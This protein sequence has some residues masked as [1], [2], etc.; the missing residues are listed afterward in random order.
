MTDT[1]TRKPARLADVAEAAGVS[2]ATASNVFN[3]PGIVRKELRD[4]VLETA[5]QIGYA[6][7]DPRARVL[8]TGK[9]GAIGVATVEPLSYFFEDSFARELMTSIARA[10]DDSGTGLSLVSSANHEQLAWNL[11]NAVVD[12][13]LLYCLEEAR[14]LIDEA[15]DRHLPYV[16]LYVDRRETGIPAVGIDEAA[17]ARLATQHLLD[18]GHRRFAILAMEFT[19]GSSGPVTLETVDTAFYSATSGRAIG[20]LD[21]LEEAGI[22]RTSVPI[23]ETLTDADTVAEA[24]ERIFAASEP[25]TAFVAQS[26]AIALYA[27][28]WLTERGIS[29]P[30][31]VSLIGFD[32]IPEAA[33]STPPLTT[34]R[35]PL[36]DIARHAVDAILDPQDGVLRKVLPVELVVRNSTAPPRR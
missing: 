15:R 34:I 12:G 4:R 16:A 30:G 14:D 29:V 17:A 24:L 25:P 9:V 32:D 36:K 35:Q 13:F 33:V 20:T 8:G 18:L 3:R 10:C 21:T 5:R 27:L 7:P 26:D 1:P 19:A 6:G 28:D 31:D 23:H 2:K 22:P 11:R